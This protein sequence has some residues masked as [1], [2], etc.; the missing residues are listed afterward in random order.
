MPAAIRIL[1][2]S[3]DLM[4][5]SRVGGLA[6]QLGA[7]VETVRSLDVAPP[8]SGY[9]VAILDLQGLSGDAAALVAHARQRLAV[10]GPV[11]GAGPALIAFGPHVAEDR[12]AAARAAGADDVVSRGELLG[13]FAAVVGRRL[14]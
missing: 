9:H 3:P 6:A 1:L 5:A 12:L 11:A 14:G 8:G 4:V 10:H 2:V 13:A 7:A